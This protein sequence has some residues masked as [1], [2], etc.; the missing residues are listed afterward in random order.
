MYIAQLHFICTTQY[1]PQYTEVGIIAMMILQ[2]FCSY[3]VAGVALH[4]IDKL[5]TQLILQDS[6]L[7]IHEETCFV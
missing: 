1:I 4:S 2:L 7:I 6:N 3:E 5:C